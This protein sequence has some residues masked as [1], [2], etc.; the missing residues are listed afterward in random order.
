MSGQIK[1]SNWKRD[2]RS[3]LLMRE[4]ELKDD[5]KIQYIFY[6]IYGWF[7]FIVINVL[8]FF[9]FMPIVFILTFLFDKDRVCITYLTKIFSDLFHLLY[10]CQRIQYDKNGMKS[11]KKGEKRIYVINHASQY[12][13]IL[14]YKMP[15]VVKFLFKKKWATLPLVGWMAVIAGNVI[16]K[17]DSK[18]ADTI[19]LFKKAE[20]LM[21]KGYP[22]VIYPEG[23]RSRDGKIGQFFHG[24]FKLALDGGADI[25]PVVFDTWN[26]IR[27]GALWI[28][29]VNPAIRI[30][31]P[32]KYDEFKHLNYVKLSNLVRERMIEGLIAL[33]K[34]RHLKEKNYYRKVP[35]F[36][37]IDKSEEEELVALK[38]YNIKKNI[39]LK[40]IEATTPVEGEK[41]DGEKEQL[42]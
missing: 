7:L 26:A 12:D 14:M 27:P 10:F 11:P 9:V 19:A 5:I 3:N 17:E 6:T 2:I 29:D 23:T 4:K 41:I 36:V 40:P 28:R 1:L 24:T 39:A 35:K 37:E 16:L 15:G 25:V 18:A 33:R 13:V 22:F 21:E 30:L 8:Q 38:E 32:I 34:E 31:E 42:A 20:T